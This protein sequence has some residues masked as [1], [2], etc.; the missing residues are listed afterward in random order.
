MLIDETFF[1]GDLYIEGLADYAGVPS[2]TNDAIKQELGSLI[3]HYE[4][5]FYRMT[6]G[7]E[8]AR[9]FVAYLSKMI[10]DEP[11]E[12][13]ENLKSMLVEQVGNRKESPVAYYI[14]FFYLRKNQTQTTSIGN[15]EE[16]QS[17]RISPCNIKM[18][19]AWNQMAYMNRYLSEYLC[20]HREEYGGYFFDDC[21]LETINTLGI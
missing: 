1:T 21:L 12:K 10:D 20:D 18:I 8:N 11:V 4:S 14:Y 9:A 3:D 5:E 17:N 7:R 13:W 15:I 2:K 6:I 19:D 16:S